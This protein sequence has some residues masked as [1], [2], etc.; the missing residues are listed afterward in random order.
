MDIKS[1]WIGIGYALGYNDGYKKG[2][3]DGY[4]T[5]AE[6]GAANPATTIVSLDNPMA[7]TVYVGDTVTMPSTVVAHYADGHTANVAVTWNPNS[8]STSTAGEYT[9]TGTVS[10]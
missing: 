9:S 8:I 10:G 5:G 6:D 3:K 7:I 2:Y 4:K 1:K